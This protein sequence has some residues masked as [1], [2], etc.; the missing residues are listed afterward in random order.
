MI[1]TGQTQVFYTEARVANLVF[2]L[3]ENYLTESGG[4]ILAIN[5][6]AQVIDEYE[7][8]G[9][10]VEQMKWVYEDNPEVECHIDDLGVKLQ[11]DLGGSTVSVFYDVLGEKLIKEL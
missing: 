10:S 11:V 8:R 1:F 3:Y 4:V 9:L 7:G 5:S 6:K 2:E